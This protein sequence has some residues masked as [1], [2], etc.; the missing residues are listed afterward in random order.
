MLTIY[1]RANSSNVQLV[2]WA[3]AELGLTWQRLDYGHGHAST[4]TPEFLA[5]NPMG[6]VPV[7]KDGQAA[8]FESAAIL[9]Y[10]GAAYGDDDFWPADP[11]VRA[12]LDQWAEWGKHCFGA[13][14]TALFYP[15][16]RLPPEA[17]A[18]DAVARAEAAIAPLAR[19]LDARLGEGPWLAG[20]A[21]SFADIAVGHLLHRYFTLPFNRV[22]TPAL[23]AYYAN[24]QTRPAYAEHAMVSYEALRGIG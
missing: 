14:V 12:R 19:M 10:L 4:R 7:L 22:E 3:V 16:V 17:A 6:Q 2:M 15:L 5:M 21:F 11:L 18:P 1:G 20:D 8:I 13:A 23:D 9:R 24:L